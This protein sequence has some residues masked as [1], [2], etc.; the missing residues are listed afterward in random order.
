MKY[1]LILG[2]LSCKIQ[3]LRAYNFITSY[4]IN[5]KILYF[6]FDYFNDNVKQVFY[7]IFSNYYR[8]IIKNAYACLQ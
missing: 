6:L 3:N 7:E 2:H 1:I 8:N 4:K 5:F